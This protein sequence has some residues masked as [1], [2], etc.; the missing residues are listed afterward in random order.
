MEEKIEITPIARIY[1]DFT[2]SFGIPKQGNLAPHLMSHIV[3]EP[4]FKVAEAFRGIE[5]FDRIWLLWLFDAEDVKPWSPT[6]RPPV[7]GGNARMGV[8]ATRSPNRKNHIGMT[9]VGLVSYEWDEK[10]GP[11]LTVSGADLRSGTRIIDIKPYIR[12]VDSFPDAVSGFTDYVNDSPLEV[13]FETNFPDDMPTEKR[14]ALEEILALNPRPRY[15]DDPMRVYGMNYGEYNISFTADDEK[16]I[17]NDITK[18]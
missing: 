17:V 2:D 15:H 8:F 5:E 18:K 7:L 10:D 3:M 1:N 16:I 12:G 14:Q 4:E 13:F 9:N 11:V 6:V